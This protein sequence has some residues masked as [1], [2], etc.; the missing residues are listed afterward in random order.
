VA[1]PR[2]RRVGELSRRRPIGCE[3]L[4]HRRALVE[5]VVVERF[6]VVEVGAGEPRQLGGD[7]QGT[8]ES[9]GRALCS[10]RGAGFAGDSARHEVRDPK[11][12]VSAEGVVGAEL[13]GLSCR[14]L[15]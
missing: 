4:E 5:L 13:A 6:V 3:E 8:L 2:P 14:R 11:L 7:A 10:L 15:R 1:L 9:T 12:L